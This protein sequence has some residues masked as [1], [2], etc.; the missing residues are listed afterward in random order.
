MKQLISFING[1]ISVDSL[2]GALFVYWT[3]IRFFYSRP[4]FINYTFYVIT[5]IIILLFIRRISLSHIIILLSAILI[6]LISDYIVSLDRIRDEIIRFI[7]AGSIGLVISSFVRKPIYILYWWLIL[8]LPISFA[9]FLGYLN[10]KFE[11]SSYMSAAYTMYYLFVCLSLLYVFKKKYSVFLIL[12]FVS[13]IAIT[14]TG[15]RGAIIASIISYLIIIL[16]K[17]KENLSFKQ[18]FYGLLAILILYSVTQPFFEDF[19]VF[20]GDVFSFNS[21]WLYLLQNDLITDS[22]GRDKVYNSII[23]SFIDGNFIGYG[24]GAVGIITDGVYQHAHNFLLELLADFGIFSLILIYSFYKLLKKSI[25]LSNNIDWQITALLLIFAAILPKFFSSTL[26]DSTTL[27]MLGI[28]IQLK[29]H[30]ANMQTGFV[31]PF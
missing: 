13:F 2:I 30:N 9:S 6:T 27:P 24:L 5:F 22:S 4:D 10:P 17:N 23:N 11:I 31:K 29:R 12:M 3:N 16:Y 8:S 25:F 21:R 28:L 1:V 7:I 19:I 14:F 20:I 15:T 26:L 18:V